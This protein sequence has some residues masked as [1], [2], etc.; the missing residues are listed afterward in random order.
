MEEPETNEA[1]DP[2]VTWSEYSSRYS[3]QEEG[4]ARAFISS[5]MKASDLV[6][7]R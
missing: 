4:N 2:E 3:V 1:D 6:D 7:L 5:D